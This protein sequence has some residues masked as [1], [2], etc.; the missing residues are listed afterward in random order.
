MYQW[1]GSGA[2]EPEGST[3]TQPAPEPSVYAAQSAFPTTHWSVILSAGEGLCPSADVAL[4]RLCRAKVGGPLSPL[5]D[6][7]V[8]IP[9]LGSRT[10]RPRS[11]QSSLKM[12]FSS[13]LAQTNSN[14]KN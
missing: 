13:F 11:R 8:P 1:D 4:E 3:L 10:L 9:V 2:Y 12:P 14:T 5:R 7:P 6:Q